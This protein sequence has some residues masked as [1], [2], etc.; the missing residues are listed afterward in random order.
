MG[1]IGKL[2][3]QA[4]QEANERNL[5][6]ITEQSGEDVE[7]QKRELE[8]IL[9]VLEYEVKQ[10]RNKKSARKSEIKDILKTLRGNR[11][12]RRLINRE[13][14]KLYK[15]EKQLEDLEDTE[16]FKEKRKNILKK[17]FIGLYLT[18]GGV[19]AAKD[20]ELKNKIARGVKMVKDILPS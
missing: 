11:K 9:E 6:V 2:K 19:I 13:D 3:R 10:A 20:P 7:K 8:E 14:K 18:I 4:I 1:R 12:L 15:L 5:G 17:I 16:T